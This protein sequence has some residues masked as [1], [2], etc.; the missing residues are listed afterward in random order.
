MLVLFKS[1]LRSKL[2]IVRPFTIVWTTKNPPWTNLLPKYLRTKQH[3][4]FFSRCFER[5]NVKTKMTRKR[6]TTEETGSLRTT[7]ESLRI[8]SR[9]VLMRLFS[10]A[11]GTALKR[12]RERERE[13]W[14]KEDR[15]DWTRVWVQDGMVCGS[16][17]VGETGPVCW[18]YVLTPQNVLNRSCFS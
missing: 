3:F 8:Q 4:R 6:Q 18:R 12:E 2:N 14:T 9:Q 1:C 7:W 13:G 16:A 17:A 11:T 5:Q 15:K 10:F